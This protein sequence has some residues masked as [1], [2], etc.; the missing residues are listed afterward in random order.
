[1]VGAA[2]KVVGDG[3]CCGCRTVHAGQYAD[4]VACGHAPIG[5]ADAHEAGMLQG[6]NR[7][8]AG[9][10]GVVA[11]EA[12]LVG[13]HVQVVRVHVFAARDGPAGE[14]DD[15]V[16]AAHGRPDGDVSHGDFVASG[17][18]SPEGDVFDLH[19]AHQLAASNQHVV[20]RV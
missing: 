14:A 2:R 5:A 11:F 15:L 13:P 9:T 1:R 6:R 3:A 16:V 12:A 8:H 18:Q 10:E 20:V 19:A 4:V 7:L 17:D